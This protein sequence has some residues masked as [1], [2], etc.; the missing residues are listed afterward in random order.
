[1]ED[2]RKY[3]LFVHRHPNACNSESSVLDVIRYAYMHQQ[4][5]YDYIATLFPNT[6][7]FEL[8][9]IT[10]GLELIEREG[11]QEVRGFNWNGKENGLLIF[12]TERLFNPP[13]ISSYVGC[14]ISGGREI[15]YKEELN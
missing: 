2:L 10:D 8:N 15:H 11:L 1:M 14:V 3:P 12:R 6:I 4:Q 9:D 7:D 5:E 13:G